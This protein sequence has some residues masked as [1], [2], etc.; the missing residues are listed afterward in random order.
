MNGHTKTFLRNCWKPVTTSNTPDDTE[1]A[2]CFA[3]IPYNQG[4]TEPNKRIFKTFSDFGAYFAKP[5]DPV[6][7][8]QRTGAIYS[9][10]CDDFDKVRYVIYWRGGSLVNFL[11][12]GEGQTCFIRNRGGSRF[13]WQGKTYSVSL[14]WFLFVNKHAK[15]TET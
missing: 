3:V 10:P 15:C 1:P 8:E 13:F 6:T 11:Q 14:S 12:I 2:T 5:K 7:K 4:V 9:I